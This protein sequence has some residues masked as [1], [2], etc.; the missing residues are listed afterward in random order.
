MTFPSGELWPQVLEI[1]K[2]STTKATF[3]TW[4][5]KTTARLE[6]DRLIVLAESNF[7]QDWLDNRLRES[8]ERAVAQVAGQ[9]V[10]IEFRVAETSGYQPELFFTGT[11]RD[12]YNAI[13]QPD[14]QHYCSRYFHQKWLQPGRGA[15][16]LANECG[17]GAQSCPRLD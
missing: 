11:Y 14:K 13:V 9:T 6:D 3:E 8:I 15:V 4:L 12:A 16:C 5:Q 1:L 7:A 2:L 10:S 17:L